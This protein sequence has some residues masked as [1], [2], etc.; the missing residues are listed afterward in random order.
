MKNMQCN[1]H[2]IKQTRCVSMNSCNY[3]YMLEWTNLPSFWANEN[4][5]GEGGG[6]KYGAIAHP[7][8]HSMVDGIYFSE[9]TS[10]KKS[11]VWYF[12]NFASADPFIILHHPSI[13]RSHPPGSDKAALCAAP[14]PPPTLMSTRCTPCTVYT[15]HCTQHTAHCTFYTQFYT[16]HCT[17]QTA[18]ST[19]HSAHGILCIL[20]LVL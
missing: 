19:L 18:H 11:R 5:W 17:L 16:L 12:C 9:P 3:F 7:S 14:A 2:T 13:I 4:S 6:S 1:K 8:K 20:C 15:T 10:L